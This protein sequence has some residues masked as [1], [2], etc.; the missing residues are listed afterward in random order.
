MKESNKEERKDNGQSI[1]DV[2]LS[3]TLSPDHTSVF[4]D[5]THIRENLPISYP[6]V[7]ERYFQQYYCTE[8]ELPND[9]L[10]GGQDHFVFRHH[11]GFSFPLSLSFRSIA[12]NTND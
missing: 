3:S 4:G 12:S 2:D 5:L 6:S 9:L 10:R 11:N 8:K 1:Q 7:V